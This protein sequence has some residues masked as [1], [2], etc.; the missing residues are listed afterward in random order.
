MRNTPNPGEPG[1]QDDLPEHVVAERWAEAVRHLSADGTGSDAL[2]RDDLPV[3]PAQTAGLVDTLPLSPA[4]GVAGAAGSAAPALAAVA[5]AEPFDWSR[6]VA[7]R[8]ALS[9]RGFMGVGWAVG[10]VRVASDGVSGQDVAPF[11]VWAI[12]VFPFAV[13]LAF[14]AAIRKRL[15]RGFVLWPEVVAAYAVPAAFALFWDRLGLGEGFFQAAT[16]F[17]VGWP[18]YA[19]VIYWSVLL[20]RAAVRAGRRRAAARG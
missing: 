2:T 16:Y 6:L 8:D 10:L 20:V 18:L 4:T 11:V 19:A 14:G 12:A 15:T 9:F 13:A 1:G 7:P 17:Y 3:V 5:P